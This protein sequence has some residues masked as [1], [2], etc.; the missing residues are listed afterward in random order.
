MKAE[1]LKKSILQYAMQ[2]KLVPQD[3]NDEP[4]SELLKRIKAEKEQLIKDGKIKKEKP[5]PQITK[6]EIPFELPKGWE[7]VRLGEIVAISTGR[8]DAN[9]ALENGQYAFFTCSYTPMKCNTYSYSGKGIILPGNG[10]NVGLSIYYEGKFDVYQRTYVLQAYS[11]LFLK[12]IHYLLIGN[13]KEYNANK[14]FGGAT[15]YIKLGNIQN[16]I[17]PLPPLAEQQ[18]I[19]KKLE[20]I[21]PL[22]DEYSKNEEE[23]SKLNETLPNKIKKSILQHAVQGKLVQQNP[24]DEPASELLKRIKSE[25]EQLIKDGKIKKEKPLLPIT[26]D[27]T[28]FELPKGWEWVRLGEIVNYGLTGS[29]EYS[30]E[31]DKNMWILDLEDIEKISS[32]LLIKNRIKN[33]TFNSTKKCFQ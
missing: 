27:E 17:V 6:E 33:K 29:L 8:Y 18:R 13:W 7:W 3:S 5:L 20:Q 4:A 11:N 15:P 16:Y 24:N 19:V 30:E 9:H 28:P 26:K 32:K 23:L 14:L 1:T 31:L 25:K 21:L 22:I 2:G 10:A 12:Y